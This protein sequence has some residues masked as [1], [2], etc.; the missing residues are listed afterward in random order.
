MCVMY[1][2]IFPTNFI[3]PA[4]INSEIQAVILTNRRTYMTV[5]KALE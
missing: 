1:Y 2:D 4:V 3:A 5:H